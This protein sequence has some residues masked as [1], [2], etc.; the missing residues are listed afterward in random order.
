MAHLTYF[1][2]LEEYNS[3][4]ASE[5]FVK[6][7]ISFCEENGTTYYHDSDKTPVKAVYETTEDNVEIPLFNN[8]AAVK[9]IIVD[10][11][12]IDVSTTGEYRYTFET[13]GEHTVYFAFKGN[14]KILPGNLFYIPSTNALKKLELADYIVGIEAQC[15]Y[16]CF[17]LTEVNIPSSLK[18]INEYNFNNCPYLEI[19]ETTINGEVSDNCFRTIKFSNPSI[20][21]NGNIGQSSF[22]STTGITTVTV[23][24]NIGKYS[25]QYLQ[26]LR[27][28]TINGNINGENIGAGVSSLEY[29]TINGNIVGNS[30][31]TNSYSNLKEVIINGSIISNSNFTSSMYMLSAITINGNVGDNNFTSSMP[32]LSS[33][34]IAGSVGNSSFNYM[35]ATALTEFNVSGVIG[36]SSFKYFSGLTSIVITRSVGDYCFY[37][38]GGLTDITFSGNSIGSIGH[39]VFTYSNNVSSVTVDSNC[40]FSG[41]LMAYSSGNLKEVMFT[42]K[43]RIIYDNFL[44]SKSLLSAVT[45]S[46]GVTTIGSYAFSSCGSL[47]SVTIPS[48]VTSIGDYAFGSSYTT[49]RNITFATT[50]SSPNVTNNTFS[51]ITGT[52]FLIH[53]G[54]KIPFDRNPT[55]DVYRDRISVI[56]SGCEELERWIKA[57]AVCDNGSKKDVERKQIST[58]NEIWYNTDVYRTGS[59]SLGSCVWAD[60]Y[61][62]DQWSASTKS[63][64]GYSVYESFSNVGMGNSQSEMQIK[65]NGKSSFSFKVRNYSESCCD[66]VVVLN[67]DDTTTR[68][69]WTTSYTTASTGTYADGYVK[70]TNRNKSSATDWYDVTFNNISSGEHTIRIIYGKDSSASYNDDK[71]YIAVPN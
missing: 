58:D 68:S 28:F 17:G 12:K 13:A 19:S 9:Y 2:T 4:V 6:P 37:Q 67:L 15:I 59:T 47:S 49:T 35:S 1:E 3:Y 70:Y 71:G 21:I 24:G 8:A 30:N 40:S 62:N 46:E 53:C 5:D 50:N 54:A 14:P 16:N 32:K 39:D 18:Y 44:Y 51:N 48:T 27:N 63:L 11:E 56:E 10:D 57:G 20:T 42:D 33:L 22:V 60:V 66:F 45:I 55:W 52:T 25:F 31:F 61:L 26:D 69:A 43:V 29:I 65:I 41:P 64:Q 23:N 38:C 34:S 36:Q 7:N